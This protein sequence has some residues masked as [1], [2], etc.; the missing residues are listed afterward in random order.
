MPFTLSH[1]LYAA[2]LRKL[3][4]SL[5]LTGLVLGSMAPDM[6]YFVAMQPYRSIG[7]SFIGFMTLG[8]PLC[9]AIACAYHWIVAP[10]LHLF[11]PAIGGINTFVHQQL[12]PRRLAHRAEWTFFDALA[13]FVWLLSAGIGFMS[14]V[15]VDSFTHSGG[16]FVQRIPALQLM[17]AGEYAHHWLQHSLSA[18]G[19]AVPFIIL[20]HRWAKWHKA[21]SVDQSAMPRPN[22]P[23][24]KRLPWKETLLLPAF[25]APF[26]LGKLLI[27]DQWLSISIWAVAPITSFLISLYFVSLIL[28][29]GYRWRKAVAIFLPSLVILVYTL[30][31]WNAER[32]LIGWIVFIWLLAASII[33]G[34]RL[35][36]QD[37]GDTCH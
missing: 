27:S 25:A 21:L 4:P 6:E 35:C 17:I 3:M 34:A 31:D 12:L 19:L 1:P 33:A 16:W 22:L 24:L 8:L 32:P 20:W 11:M 30:L 37:S 14:H 13:I 36:C 29:T 7:H 10:R 23:F 5:S 28:G 15:F 9:L 26:L 18:L 2:P